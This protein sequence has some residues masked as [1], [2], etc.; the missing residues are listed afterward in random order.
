L[1][2]R[3]PVIW[4]PG[5]AENCGS[6]LTKPPRKLEEFMN[7]EIIDEIRRFRDE[8]ARQCGY[9]IHKVFED[10]REGTEK[11]KAEG[12]KVV[13]PEPRLPREPVDGPY[14]LREEPKKGQK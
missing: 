12:W 3:F 11:L 7:N 10:I 4:P 8:H 9:D 2:L 6:P 13:S 1:K 14:V 5:A